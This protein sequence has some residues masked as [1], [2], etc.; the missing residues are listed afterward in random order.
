MRSLDE[1]TAS[2]KC[3]VAAATPAGQRVSSWKLKGCASEKNYIHIMVFFLKKM[4]MNVTAKLGLELQRTSV[5]NVGDHML[6]LN[7]FSNRFKMSQTSGAEEK[8]ERGKKK[9]R[10]KYLHKY[11]QIVFHP[12]CRRSHTVSG[13][14]Y[15]DARLSVLAA[16][17][18]DLWSD[19]EPAACVTVFTCASTLGL[20]RVQTRFEQNQKWAQPF[21]E[22]QDS[23]N[24]LIHPV[25]HH[26]PIHLSGLPISP[27]DS[28]RTLESGL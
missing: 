25:Q 4:W 24:L 27:P 21:A 20:A 15:A 10:E 18:N 11:L 2:E 3:I 13:W 19:R 9:K 22:N 6:M 23:L 28:H 7:S 17:F 1:V 5:S 14:S 12:A 16:F 26:P 8:K